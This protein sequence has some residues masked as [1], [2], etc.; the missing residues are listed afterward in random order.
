M[1]TAAQAAFDRVAETYDATFTDSL[2]GRA[3]RAATWREAVAVLPPGGHILEL[4]C[5]T[6][7]DA[8]FLARNGFTVTALD[9]SPRMVARARAR[10]A[11]E[12]PGAPVAFSV[13]CTERLSELAPALRFDGVF[14]N[15]S[16]LN[17][18]A[19]LA[20]VARDLAGR[21]EPGAPLLLCLS[22]RLCLWE[23]VHYLARG[24]PRK[25]LRRL[26]G[27]AHARVGELVVPVFYPTPGSV[28]ESFGE[29]FRLRSITGIGILVPP[30]YLEGWA[31]RHRAVLDLSERLDR[32]L[33][34]LPGVRVLGDHM[35]LNLERV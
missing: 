1:A 14:S 7:E 33:R 26:G 13:L 29:L 18:V 11:A 10:A 35:L 21:L 5:G 16:G 3:Q 30:S 12:A 22:T 17:C 20:R 19:D 24:N 8:L 25:A 23:V 28:K 27:R 34:R 6:G 9:A 32:V 15:F 2:I 31:R 4:N